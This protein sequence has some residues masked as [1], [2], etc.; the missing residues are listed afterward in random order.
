VLAI[1]F[2]KWWFSQICTILSKKAKE[3]KFATKN[4]TTTSS[5]DSIRS[6]NDEILGYFMRE[7]VQQK[8][9]VV[10]MVQILRS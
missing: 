4:F 2:R 3:R 7:E 1:W 10:T 8:R 9:F 5:G 6:Q